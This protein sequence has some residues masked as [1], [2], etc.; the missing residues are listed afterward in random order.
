M[1]KADLAGN[2]DVV[3][4]FRR[5]IQFCTLPHVPQSTR[6]LLHTE[7][8]RERFEAGRVI[9]FDNFVE[10]VT[11]DPSKGGCGLET[12]A[13]TALLKKA[14]DDDTLDLWLTAIRAKNAKAID[15]DTPD[16]KEHAGQVRDAE[17]VTNLNRLDDA[18]YA[19]A[20]LRRDRPDIHARVLAGEISAHAGMIAAGFRKR[21]ASRRKPKRCPHCGGEL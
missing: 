18:S 21:R 7:A 9:K 12:E 5:A 4:S 13:V 8:W 11:K 15:A 14:G 1:L 2:T 3:L 20:R 10:F 16:L 17:N 19:H 6:R